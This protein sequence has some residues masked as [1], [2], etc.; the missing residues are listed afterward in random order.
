MMVGFD[1]TALD[2]L[3]TRWKARLAHTD[4]A[5]AEA[6]RVAIHELKLVIA[7]SPFAVKGCDHKFVDSTRCLKCGWSP[8]AARSISPSL[9]PDDAA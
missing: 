2:Q 1:P 9:F 6:W 4:Q 7:V 5:T 3:L 8:S